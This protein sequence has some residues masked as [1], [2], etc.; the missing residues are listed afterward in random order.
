MCEH[1]G[2]VY[3]M[4]DHSTQMNDENIMI[5][6][7][8]SFQVRHTR[9]EELG[10]AVRGVVCIANGRTISSTMVIKIIY[11]I[12][13]G[14]TIWLHSSLSVLPIPLCNS[15]LRES[16]RNRTHPG[17]ESTGK[18]PMAPGVRMGETSMDDNAV[19]TSAG[20]CLLSLMGEW[21]AC[22]VAEA[23]MDDRPR[24]FFLSSLAG[25]TTLVAD[26]PDIASVE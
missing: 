26:I 5:P 22:Q 15:L 11:N 9:L 24:C 3:E 20:F 23:W 7:F 16:S 25:D 2:P 13:V 21:I 19:A 6:C 10:P 14:G 8:D 12:C 17:L 1:V 4:T 18:P